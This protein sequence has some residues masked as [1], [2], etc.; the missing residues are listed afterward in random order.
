MLMND[1]FIKNNAGVIILITWLMLKVLLKSKDVLYQVSSDL[2][3]GNCFY[4]SFA[5]AGQKVPVPFK[6]LKSPAWY[7]VKVTG[8]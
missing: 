4:S 7:R 6:S 3:E 1:E 5:D 8:N 2:G